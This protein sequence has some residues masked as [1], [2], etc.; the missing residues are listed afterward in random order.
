MSL[1]AIFF[2]FTV[3]IG[4]VC[5]FCPYGGIWSPGIMV[6]AAVGAREAPAKTAA[7]GVDSLLR[8]TG[9]P[10]ASP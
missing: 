9:Q 1:L 4:L 3:E 10:V 6:E 2:M 7:S 5:F 8:E